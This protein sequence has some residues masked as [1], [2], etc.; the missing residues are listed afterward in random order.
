MKYNPVI[1]ALPEVIVASMR[2]TVKNYDEFFKVV[3]KM[4]EEMKRQG[5]ICAEP[6]YCFNIYHDGEYKEKDID[7]EVCEA[8]VD[9]CED[10]ELVKYKIVKRIDKAAC[11]LHKGSY[12]TIRDAYAFVYKWIKDNNYQVIGE[13]RESYIDGIWNKEDPSGWLTEIQISII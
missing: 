5:A 8:V 2:L 13:T 6:D 10:S 11:V 7:V 4:G 9:F 3:P 1:K 12:E